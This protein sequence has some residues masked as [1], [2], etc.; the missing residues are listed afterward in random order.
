MKR[1]FS[2]IVI[3]IVACSVVLAATFTLGRL[4]H[5]PNEKAIANSNHAPQVTA[6]VERRSLEAEKVEVPGKL[7]LGT[8]WKVTAGASDGELS[9]VTETYLGA[10]DTLQSG[11]LLA[12]VSGRPVIGLQLPFNLYRN[13]SGG[14]SG[15]DVE[16]LQ[17]SL[18]NLGLYQSEI[19]G[20]YGEVT[21]HAVELLYDG[22]NTERPAPE[23]SALA[24]VV[25]AQDT[26]EK[27]KAAAGAKP[28]DK[29]A[30][31]AVASAEKQLSE[32]RII[33]LT[34]VLRSEIISLPASQATVVSISPVNTDL[35]A[36][37]AVL[38]ELRSG[39]AVVT[40]RVGMADKESFAV[41]TKVEVHS[42]SDTTVVVPGAIKAMGPFTQESST[43]G[44]DVPGYDVSVELAD[45]KDMEDGGSVILSAGSGEKFEGISVPVTALRKDGNDTF[46]VKVGSDTHVTVKIKTI[47]D[48]YAIL[49]GSPLNV[50]E[51]VIVSQS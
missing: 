51:K 36:D 38:A 4:V 18:Q 47:N 19:D 10:G 12:E 2:W 17:Y 11:H 49:D 34:P 35:N 14:D 33:A 22:T 25:A 5:S 24:D 20:V 26:L 30:V 46:V 48:G 8:S 43:T 45:T 50:G 31:D 7:A 37:G 16:K 21:A 41:G 23:G 28:E 27:A 44:N 29:A 42:A 3:T 6:Q 40:A 13:I 1:K 9:V 15:N 39:A 32:K